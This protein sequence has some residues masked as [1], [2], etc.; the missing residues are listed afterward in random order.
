[1]AHEQGSLF[2]LREGDGLF[3]GEPV[4]APASVPGWGG[5]SDPHLAVVPPTSAPPQVSGAE[6]PRTPPEWYDPPAGQV[7]R[8]RANLAALRALRAAPESQFAGEE[9][10]RVLARWS[11]WGALP[12]MFDAGGEL[13][14]RF[15]GEL[16]ELMSDEEI[17][18]AR[19]STI[20]A[21]YTSPD[22]A[23]CLWELAALLGGAQR[24]ER[25]FEP[26][27]GHGSFM[28]AAPPGVGIVGAERDPVTAAICGRLHP[29]HTVLAAQVE[30][31]GGGGFDGAV[32]NVPFSK[33]APFDHRLGMATAL[34][35]H[36][37]CLAKSLDLCMAGGLVV[38][39][40]SRWT[41]DA[42]SDEQRRE[43]A[44]W[45]QLLGAIRLPS[46][47]FRRFAGTEVV[48]DAV[49]FARRPAVLKEAPK[50]ADLEAWGEAAWLSTALEGGQ[51]VN[52]WLVD[53]PEMVLGEIATGMGLYGSEDL[54]VRPD[55][56]SPLADQMSAAVGRLAEAA[57]PAADA[58]R[59]RRAELGDQVGATA[60]AWRPPEGWEQPA[61]AREGSVFFD[62]EFFCIASGDAVPME[63]PP[64]KPAQRR[65]RA[66]CALRDATRELIVAYAA[67][68]SD[69]ARLQTRLAA[70]Y[71]TAVRSTGHQSLNEAHGIAS[72][73][74]LGGF[75][76]DPD[77]QLLLGLERQL[78]D[79]SWAK[80]AVF[81]ESTV[82][83][84]RRPALVDTL[85]EAL[86]ESMGRTGGVDVALM[87]E[88]H[89]GEW[90]EADLVA[91]GLAFED[92]SSRKLEAAA[93]Y[94]GGNVRAKLAEAK[95][96]AAADSSYDVNVAALEA[97]VPDDVEPG[98]IEV[99]CGSVLL[100]TK[101]V[102]EFVVAVLG[103]LK[104][105]DV[106]YSPEA[107]WLIE[108]DGP[109]RRGDSDYL[110]W[111]TDTRSPIRIMNTAWAGKS[112]QVTKTVAVVRADGSR[113]EAQVPDPVETQAVQE[114]VDQLHARLNEWLWN[115]DPERCDRIAR[116][117]NERY[118]AWRRP[119]Y[120]ESWVRPPGL[121][122]GRELYPHQL[123][124]A[125]HVI[126]DGDYLLAH[127]VG[128]GKT[129]TM[130][131][132]AVETRRLGIASKPALV[133]PNHLVSQT[134]VEIQS[135]F[136]EASVLIPTGG[137]TPDKSDR[138]AFA[139]RCALGD[140]DLVV[141]PASFFDMLPVAPEFTRTYVRGKIDA[142]RK[143]MQASRDE[144]KSGRS[145]VKR[146]E[147]TLLQY[148]KN[149]AELTHKRADDMLLFEDLG[150]DFLMVDEAHLYKNLEIKSASQDL[151]AKGSKRAV[152]LEQKLQWLRQTYPG[153][154]V[155]VLATGTPVAN[156][157]LELAVMARYVMPGTLEELGLDSFDAFVATFCRRSTRTEVRPMG[158]GWCDKERI[159]HIINAPELQS[160]L[161]CRFDIRTADDLSLERPAVRGGG[162][163]KVVVEPYGDLSAYFD[164]L[165]E[166][167]SRLSGRP[168]KG[169]DNMLSI[170]SAARHASLDLRA[171][172]IATES[173]TKID[174]CAQK[175]AHIYRA[176]K[177][178]Q[179]RLRAGGV[180][181]GALQLV[182]CDLATPGKDKWSAYDDLK[183]A[184]AH[185]AIPVDKIEFIHHWDK[186][187]L[188]LFDRCR[189]GEVSVL[190]GSTEKMGTGMNVQDRLAAVH[191]L[192]FPWRPCD[193]E[194][195]EGRILR[196][197]NQHDE[198]D[199]FAYIQR[200]SGDTFLLE[201][202][203]RKTE[204]I[205]SFMALKTGVRVI[206]DGDLGA[207]SIS[208]S[209]MKAAALESP[210]HARRAVLEREVA[211]LQAALSA[212][213]AT[214]DRTAMRIE[215]YQ[216]T[217][218]LLESG[219]DELEAQ[220]AGAGPWER[221]EECPFPEWVADQLGR[222]SEW[223]FPQ[224]AR[225]T[226]TAFQFAPKNKD[227]RLESGR[228][229]AVTVAALA[230]FG[231]RWGQ[232]QKS[233]FR[234]VWQ[235]GPPAAK[236][237][238][239]LVAGDKPTDAQFDRLDDRIAKAISQKGVA[240]VS[241]MRVEAARMR[242]EASRASRYIGGF[243]RQGDLDRLRTE[244]EQ[245]A[246]AIAEQDLGGTIVDLPA[247]AVSEPGAARDAD[248]GAGL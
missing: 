154:G 210:L 114:R 129:A 73:S 220:L 71:K 111:E 70:A 166:R 55:E 97:V 189:S 62:G 183:A 140:W 217:A 18:A 184:M 226:A 76:S 33:V 94:L 117:W 195:R 207:D 124:A 6:V 115:E 41:L 99:R 204:F 37:Y 145:R 144:G 46:G 149:M 192:D 53:R 237:E 177:D 72:R 200:G 98:E 158:R 182:F 65:L 153:R 42:A 28:S 239:E 89:P 164:W 143:A 218:P 213:Q 155:C 175:A 29:A 221:P 85:E 206:E 84:R 116:R 212:H 34:S 219:A 118:R 225:A 96:A 197:G 44:R 233:S 235:I 20:N 4:G 120:P 68:N 81:T 161:S 179:Y 32:G 185:H 133:V 152:D 222:Y 13:H 107:G 63:A 196:P 241:E 162:T 228:F 58:A 198:V 112:T 227:N 247:G 201:T 187:R 188:E 54:I 26:G 125:A 165:E 173:P 211:Q 75:S 113:G 36:N 126:A 110:A 142:L 59:A 103:P 101:E 8:V 15:G 174:A 57:R 100:T 130:G 40:T 122:R 23:A 91:A 160:I 128:A 22:I 83:P 132:V 138:S 66:A 215:H 38:A 109:V 178:R 60:R 123:Q 230:P 169:Q 90:G 39:I 16:R 181:P 159:T 146:Q 137:S 214:Q 163:Q 119:E 56:S 50:A 88:V 67:E 148:E 14:S 248:I 208:F 51:M 168:G 69:V 216:V 240:R 87:H 27:C 78:P 2:D 246:A 136:P 234:R 93:R 167:A 199:V 48:V 1:M 151:S 80:S 31:V 127:S 19:L 43:L 86:V 11:G 156:K 95:E 170:V 7:G 202:L 209:D 180:S 17:A 134:A 244:L 108:A 47:A 106:S 172:G 79:G 74:K 194:Q 35:L 242:E 205:N 191:H 229:G 45:G 5:V 171:V 176:H 193:L 25:W 135:W 9:Q 203:E 82:R 141:L 12:Q 61:W 245:V 139:A 243:D 77:Y 190:I 236:L 21:H 223:A 30:M 52:E 224:F 3:G 232:D 150:I 24:G 92:P 186:K 10:R 231:R 157:L 102:A 64:A 49:V 238:V 147:Q 131:A 105:L 104:A 121:A